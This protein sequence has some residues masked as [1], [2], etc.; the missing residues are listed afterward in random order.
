MTGQSE[1][2]GLSGR[3][4]GSEEQQQLDDL[5]KFHGFTS[6][7]RDGNAGHYVAPR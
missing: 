1:R 5:S 2:F 4:C 3:V 6:W 7:S